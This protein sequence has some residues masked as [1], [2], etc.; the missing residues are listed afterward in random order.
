MERDILRLESPTAQVR[1]L[2]CEFLKDGKAH[3][4]KEIIQYIEEQ[5]TMLQLQNFTEG[6][7]SG[8]IHQAIASLECE[9]LG[10]GTFRIKRPQ[11]ETG[12]LSEETER[13]R[14]DKVAEILQN[15]IQQLTALAR[16]I[17]YINADDEE[18]KELEKIKK[19]VCSLREMEAAQ[20]C[21]TARNQ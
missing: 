9:R 20:G 5:K 21:S 17:D 6:H 16:E 10:R 18:I 11:T 14:R 3:S 1:M 2:T 19:C 4:R 15:A 13:S 8:G 7:I 12:G